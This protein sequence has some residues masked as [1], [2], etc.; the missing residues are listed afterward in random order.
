[1]AEKWKPIRGY[2]GYEISDHGN[3]RSLKSGQVR[4]MRQRDK[5]GKACAYLRK[6]GAYRCVY[7]HTAV[8]ETFVSPRPL[9]HWPEWKNGNFSDNRLLNLVWVPRAKAKNQKRGGFGRSPTAGITVD[10]LVYSR[11]QKWAASQNLSMKSVVE[12]L[13]SDFLKDKTK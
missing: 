2:D 8:L 9:N 4:L 1:M 10:Y 11:I 7:L 6:E 5:N 12:G 13:I 3:L